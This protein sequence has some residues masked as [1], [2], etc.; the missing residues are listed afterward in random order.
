MMS[1]SLGMYLIKYSPVSIP[2]LIVCYLLIMN[3]FG[4]GDSES[5]VRE[6]NL[7]LPLEVFIEDAKSF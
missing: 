1:L 6:W 7:L 4:K 5:V 3:K 2:Q